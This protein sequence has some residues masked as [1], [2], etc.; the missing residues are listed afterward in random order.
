[1]AETRF[2]IIIII[3]SLIVIAIIVF[4]A[5]FTKRKVLKYFPSAFFS[6]IAIGCFIKSIYFSRSFEDI[7]FMLMTIIA[8]IL[9]VTAIITARTFGF[10]FK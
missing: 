7:A 1:M 4:I 8:V 2:L 3:L 6:L 5:R 9:T 10:K